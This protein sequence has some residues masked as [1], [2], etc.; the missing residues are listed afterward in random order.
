MKKGEKCILYCHPDYAYGSKGSPPKIPE[1]AT[2]VFEVELFKWQMED[3]SSDKDNG[4]LRSIITEGEG[5][6]TPGE[7]S[8]VE[9]NYEMF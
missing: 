7:G 5:Y 3:V 4:I 9:G 8:N 1:N 2:L 6:I